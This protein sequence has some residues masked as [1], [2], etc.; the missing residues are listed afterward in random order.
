MSYA[1]GAEHQAESKYCNY[2]FA[3]SPHNEGT[4]ALLH[5]RSNV[6]AQANSGK[7]QQ[8][9]PS[10]KI[11]K[12]SGLRFVED[13]KAG[14]SRDDEKSEYKFRKLIP[15]ELRLVLFE[16][17]G[18]AGSP[19]QRE[20][21][22]YESD[23]SVARG[24]GQHGE[25]LCSIGIDCAR[26]NRFCGVVN[27]ESGPQAKCVVRHSQRVSNKREGEQGYSAQGENR[28][29]RE[30]SVFIVGLDCSLRCNDR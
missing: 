25:F 30:R 26:R 14:K 18:F 8:K 20:C 22:H 5:H 6:R 9:R 13:M 27:R 15:E 1:T 2:D 24:L 23:H 7:R 17:G 11:P 19:A 29:D 4:Y 21:E 28:S 16:L 10:R 3:Q 12:S